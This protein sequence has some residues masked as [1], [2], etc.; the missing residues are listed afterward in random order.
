MMCSVFTAEPCDLKFE[1]LLWISGIC[2]DNLIEWYGFLP[3]ILFERRKSKTDD[4][5][6]VAMRDPLKILGCKSVR[7][8]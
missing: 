3:T 1:V 8:L 2:D 7:G 4:I 5:V 6:I